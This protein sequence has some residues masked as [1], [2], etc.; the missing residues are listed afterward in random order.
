MPKKEPP[1]WGG[2]GGDLVRGLVSLVGSAKIYDIL[3][4]LRLKILL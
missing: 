4:L 1:G 2:L 3:P